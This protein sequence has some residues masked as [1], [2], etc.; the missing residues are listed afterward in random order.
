MWLAEGIEIP[1]YNAV[2]FRKY[3]SD[4]KDDESALLSKSA[5]MYPT[6]GG[7]LV[8][9]RWTFPAGS[10]ITLGGIA[11]DNALLSKQGKEFHRVAFDELTHF[12]EMAYQFISTTRIRKVLNFPIRCGTAAAANPGGP[13]HQWVKDRFIT[14]EAIVKVKEIPTNEPTPFGMVFFKDRDTCY[15]PSRAADNPALDVEDYI[16]RLCR[17]KNPVERA[18][19]MNGDWGVSPEGLIKPHWLR[20]FTMRDRMVDLLVSVKQDG[21]GILHTD[22]VLASFHEGECRRF[23]TI[24]T[25]GG[26]KDITKES[27]G[28]PASWTVVGIWDYKRFRDGTPVLLCRHVWRDRRGFTEIAAKLVELHQVWKPTSMKVENMTMGPDLVNLLMGTIPISCISTEGKDKVT[29]MTP[30]L[31]LMEQGRVYLPKVENTWKP[32]LEAE[33]LGWQG[34]EEEVN[35]Q[36]D[37]TAYAAIEAGGFMGNVLKMEDDPR[38]VA[39]ERVKNLAQKIG[40]FWN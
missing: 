31:N 36:I 1:G 24:D 14:N 30:A 40:G 19:M 15:I 16:K 12:T 32:V 11:H 7:K 8:G 37:M 3:E 5:A 26:S 9:T 33:W 28:K 23:A 13:G 2:I 17:N 10:S 39:K 6:L 20:Y 18:R 21:G 27:K 34:L 38:S 25:A 35:D 22:E 4:T 29:R